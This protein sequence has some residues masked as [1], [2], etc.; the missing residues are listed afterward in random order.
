[1]LVFYPFCRGSACH[2][3]KVSSW[4]ARARTTAPT[5]GRPRLQR[6]ARAYIGLEKKGHIDIGLVS[7]YTPQPNIFARF[8]RSHRLRQP[9]GPL[10]PARLKE[11]TQEEQK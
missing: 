6:G 11:P 2:D 10:F 8:A 4:F 1:M 7:R 5:T 9:P 3:Q